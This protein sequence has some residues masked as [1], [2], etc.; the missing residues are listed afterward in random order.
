[1]RFLSRIRM[2]L[3]ALG[4]LAVT[5]VAVV[6]APG[7]ALWSA[8]GVFV[9]GMALYFRIGTPS[10]RPVSIAAPVPDSWVALNSP[11]SRIP[12]HGIQAWA[13]AY[14]VDLVCDPADRSRPGFGWWPLARRPSEFPGFGRPVRAP[15]DGGCRPCARCGP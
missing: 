15:R 14:A 2:P 13:Q 11:T 4:V 12:S 7:W 8:T 3:A 10:G 1:M 9:V 5:I 6:D